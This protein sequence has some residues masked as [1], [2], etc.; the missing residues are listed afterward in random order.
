MRVEALGVQPR[1]GLFQARLIDICEHDFG[2]AA[3]KLGGG[4]QADATR[5]A[6]D[7][8]SAA[9]KSV[10]VTAL[11]FRQLPASMGRVT[12]VM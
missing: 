5:T 7:Y 4:G 11:Y 10:H 12:P 2:A 9:F 1:D 6:S 8:R 3:S